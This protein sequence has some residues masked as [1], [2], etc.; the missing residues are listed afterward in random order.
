MKIVYKPILF[1]LGLFVG[2]CTAVPFV[3]TTY[4][5]PVEEEIEE[6]S[7]RCVITA[8]YEALQ[9]LKMRGKKYEQN[10]YECI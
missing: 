4:V 2:G 10:R 1:V 7:D 3:D 6:A 5:V 8:D 9:W